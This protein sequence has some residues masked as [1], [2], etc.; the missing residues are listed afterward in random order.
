ML[1]ALIATKHALVQVYFQVSITLRIMDLC[2][3]NL[4]YSVL[5]LQL[6]SYQEID[7]WSLRA[8]HQPLVR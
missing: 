4:L 6:Q 8:G 5:D 2:Y 3:I 7:Q 1:S